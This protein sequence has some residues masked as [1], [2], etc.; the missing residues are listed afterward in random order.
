MVLRERLGGTGAASPIPV[1]VVVHRS[2]DAARPDWE[3]FDGHGRRFLFQTSR[4]LTAW[5]ATLG[6]ARSVD[7]RIAVV[8]LDGEDVALFPLVRTERRGRSEIRW[9]GDDLV[10]YGAPALGPSIDRLDARQWASAWQQVLDAVGPADRIVLDRQPA[11][12]LTDPNPLTPTF[13][14]ATD[15]ARIA[16]LSDDWDTYYASRF[17]GKTRRNFARRTRRMV[18]EHGEP[19]FEVITE[20]ARLDEFLDTMVAQKRRRYADTGLSDLFD[21]PAYARF[22]QAYTEDQLATGRVHLSSLRVGETVLATHWGAIDGTTFYY[23]VPTF[24][25]DDWSKFSPG[26]LMLEHL[27]AWCI[28]AGIDRFD[29]TLGPER[30]KADWADE[31]L[32]LHETAVNL[33]LAAKGDAAKRVARQGAG[34]LARSTQRRIRT[35][36]QRATASEE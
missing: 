29:F 36:A 12:I 4:W 26:R 1:D 11:T 31:E 7:L 35:V 33:S 20:L 27:I 30:Y 8:T 21:E 17:S 15:V 13:G 9:A 23:L 25:G 28:D 34:R 10:D 24:A 5:A 14:A 16:N 32:P 22:F 6:A 18:E 19:S 3:R 2:I